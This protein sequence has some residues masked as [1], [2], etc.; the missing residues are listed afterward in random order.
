MC[1][2]TLAIQPTGA[3]DPLQN[4]DRLGRERE[5]PNNNREGHLQIGNTFY[6]SANTQD[7]AHNIY[8]LKEE[9]PIFMQDA[10]SSHYCSPLY[11]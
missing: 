11:S 10:K 1:G 7:T 6:K 3:G 8:V 5:G 9:K 2:N 4:T